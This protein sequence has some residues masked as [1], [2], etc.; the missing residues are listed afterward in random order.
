MRLRGAGNGVQDIARKLGV[1]FILD[2]S[3]RKSGDKLRVILELRDLY[4]DDAR[5]GEHYDGTLG[6]LF[7]I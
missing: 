1:D 6:D 5:W 4:S 3:V 7:D 2:G